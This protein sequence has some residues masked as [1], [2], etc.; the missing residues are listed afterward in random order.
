MVVRI[1]NTPIRWWWH[2]R[3]AILRNAEGDLS[4]GRERLRQKTNDYG[5]ADDAD[6]G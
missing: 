2:V 5:T 4:A 3:R 6:N 1:G